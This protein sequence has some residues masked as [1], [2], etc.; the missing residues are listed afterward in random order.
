LA[1]N[2]DYDDAE[3]LRLLYPRQILDTHVN[4]MT[5]AEAGQAVIRSDDEGTD[6]VY[7]S[8]KSSE[9]QHLIGS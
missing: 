2:L 9:V 8:L 4:F 6:I 1:F 3:Q 5:R 7:F